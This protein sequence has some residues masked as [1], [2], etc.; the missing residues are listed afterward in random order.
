MSGEKD[1]EEEFTVEE[2]LWNVFTFYTLRGDPMDPE[3]MSKREFVKFCRDCLIVP[4]PSV[5]DP[6]RS[7]EET[8]R[9]E[10]SE[11]LLQHIMSRHSNYIKNMLS[12]AEV[13]VI[14]T[15]VMRKNN[16]TT[17]KEKMN[18]NDFLNALMKISIELYVVFVINTH[19][20]S[21]P[22]KSNR[23]GT[24]KTVSSTEDAFQ[25]LLIENILNPGLAKRRTPRISDLR[26][27][28]QESET[29]EFLEKYKDATQ[30]IF[31]YYAASRRQKLKGIKAEHKKDVHV[32]EKDFEAMRLE[33]LKISAGRLDREWRRDPSKRTVSYDDFFKFTLDFDLSN[34]LALSSIEM[35]TVYL[36]AI[37]KKKNVQGYVRN[38]THEDFQRALVYCAIVA[39]EKKMQAYAETPDV[40][41]KVQLALKAYRDNRVTTLDKIRSLFLHMWRS[42]RGVRA[43]SAG[44]FQSF[45]TVHVFHDVTRIFSHILEHRYTKRR[46]SPKQGY[47]YST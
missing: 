6:F 45:H 17:H 27:A 32:G 4:R 13:H 8:E 38:L 22:Y 1:D 26:V 41:V 10:M 12:T 9:I 20:V 14:Y 37:H 42:V 40:D 46:T 23:Y 47:I 24:E 21:R 29:K 30:Q 35:G 3:H 16:R 7:K 5:K 2:S 15:S 11:I 43:R 18:Y 33:K 25:N 36:S 39:Y 34:S 19:F 28:M 44:E 31:R